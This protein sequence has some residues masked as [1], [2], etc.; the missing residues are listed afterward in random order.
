[1]ETINDYRRS[2]PLEQHL[3]APVQAPDLS[4]EA[5]LTEGIW[6]LRGDASDE[7]FLRAVQAQLG[8]SLP[9]II[10][11]T[12]SDG[13]A[14]AICVGPDEWYLAYEPRHLAL[15]LEIEEARFSFVDLSDQMATIDVSGMKARDLLSKAVSL[16]LHPAIFGAGKAARTLAAKAQVIIRHFEER[17]CYRITVRRSFAN[18]LWDWLADS[19]KEYR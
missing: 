4:I 18:Y 10:G 16:D 2:L 19:A 17:P 13:A 6:N 12:S 1:M 5:V 11:E 7:F 8:L 9:V 15:S 3:M 14:T